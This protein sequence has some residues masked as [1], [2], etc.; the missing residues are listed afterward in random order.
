MTEECYAIWLYQDG[1]RLYIWDG[2]SREDAKRIYRMY[3]NDSDYGMQLYR[4][5]VRLKCRDAWNEMGINSGIRLRR[6]RDR[7]YRV[8]EAERF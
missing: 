5:G 2:L 6:M 8:K 7:I 1:Y 3:F 4:A